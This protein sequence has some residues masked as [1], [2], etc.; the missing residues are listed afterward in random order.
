[1]IDRDKVIHQPSNLTHI[2]AICVVDNTLSI[3][4]PPY[5][6]DSC[7]TLQSGVQSLVPVPV[8]RTLLLRQVDLLKICIMF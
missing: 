1:M 4:L 3:P 5:L 7:P 8:L 2:D 6:L